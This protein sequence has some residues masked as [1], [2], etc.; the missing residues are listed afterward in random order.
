MGQAALA[1]SRWLGGGFFLARPG[2][3]R[4]SLPISSAARSATV[5]RARTAKET[6]R[7]HLIQRAILR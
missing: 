7:D 1:L 6:L 5:G 3:A 4:R 2:S